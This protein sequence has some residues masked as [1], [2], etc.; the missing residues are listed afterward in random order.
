MMITD[1]EVEEGRGSFGP[2]MTGMVP[3]FMVNI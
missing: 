2:P 3:L 1:A